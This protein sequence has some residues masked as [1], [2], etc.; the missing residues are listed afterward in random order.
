MK[1]RSLLVF[2]LFVLSLSFFSCVQ[3]STIEITNLPDKVNL[4]GDILLIAQIKPSTQDVGVNWSLDNQR[5]IITAEG[6]FTPLEYGIVTVTATSKVDQSTS[7]SQIVTIV[8]TIG[9]NLTLIGEHNLL[10]NQEYL[11]TLEEEIPLQVQDYL[12]ES[13]SP[14]LLE[15]LTPGK[16]KA[17]GVGQASLLITNKVD[18]L[19]KITVT[20]NISLPSPVSI[21]ITGPSSLTLD[22]TSSSYSASVLPSDAVQT[23]E[24]SSS[25]P[26]VASISATGVV[27]PL[28]VG[29]TTIFAKST[30]NPLIT[31]SLDLIIIEANPTEIIIIG[32]TN[33][34]LSSVVQYSANVLPISANQTVTWSTN[35]ANIATI[36][37]DGQLTILQTG[38]VNVIATSQVDPNISTSIHLVISYDVPSQITISGPTDLILS[39]LTA[40]YTTTILP[41]NAQQLFTWSS[42]NP[43][44]ATINQNGLLTI[45]QAGVVTI[46]VTSAILDTV[47]QNYPVNINYDAPMSF[48]IN[49]P[50]QLYYSDSSPLYTVSVLPVSASQEVEWSS[51]NL[52]VGTISSS[53]LLTITG[54]GTTIIKAINLVNSS[55]TD[56]ISLTVIPDLPQSITIA[57]PSS[58]Y[59]GEVDEEYTATV[60]PLTAIQTGNWSVISGDSFISIDPD[61]NIILIHA[62]QEGT[63]VFR[64]TTSDETVY[65]EKFITISLPHASNIEVTSE[66]YDNIIYVG[67]SLL[68]E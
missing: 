32:L 43:S 55:I 41:Q 62:N 25:N 48:V 2:F 58:I 35:N 8:K 52:T 31:A 53:G 59:L 60:F 18:A 45:L 49:G 1:K 68:L 5:A 34:T 29:S 42:L 56:Q 10:I 44:I 3:K 28:M 63:V 11:Y 6:L 22:A 15:V 30:V 17:N 21:N 24:W 47:F 36:D 16:L 12:W 7:I 20:F 64:F 33:L 61:E 40:S 46:R 13:Q 66:I 19:N 39:Q 4:G 26:M 37:T 38:V 50:T 14:T 27:T 57:G 9:Q 23:V 51:S 65:L 67:E 54:L